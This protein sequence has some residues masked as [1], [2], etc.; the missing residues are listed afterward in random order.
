M[1]EGGGVERHRGRCSA[2]ERVVFVQSV[3]RMKPFC[4]QVVLI[5]ITPMLGVY[6]LNMWHWNTFAKQVAARHGLPPPQR[7]SPLR[8]TLLVVVQL[9]V[10]LLLAC[11][12]WEVCG[13]LAGWKV[14]GRLLL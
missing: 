5:F 1:R 2:G 14:D 13:I 7:T 11:L 12:V 9:H 6:W 10:A 4:L 3:G 8:A